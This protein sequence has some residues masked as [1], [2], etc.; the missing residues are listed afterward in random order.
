MN[1]EIKVKRIKD[2]P[3]PQVIEKGDWIDLYAGADIE[4]GN[5]PITLVPLG[6]AMMLPKGYEAIIAC[7]SSTPKK[8]FVWNAGAIGVIDNSF[9]GNGDE[10]MWPVTMIG[11]ERTTIHKGDR[12]CQFRIQLSQKATIWQRIK[13][14]FTSGV[15]ITE[16]ESLN[17][18]SRGGFGTTGKRMLNEAV[19]K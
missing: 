13:W 15:K 12:I 11:A 8:F 1:A 7:R 14:L 5:T 19:T 18:T 6:V 3:L 4:I 17:N 10:W 16:V 9:C 2:V